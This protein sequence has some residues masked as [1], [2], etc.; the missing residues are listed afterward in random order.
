MAQPDYGVAAPLLGWTGM[1][2]T[3]SPDAAIGAV[4]GGCL[5]W[6]M[7]PEIKATT[8]VPLLVGSLGAGYAFGLPMG[9]GGWAMAFSLVGAT[10][11]YAALESIRYTMKP[12]VEVPPWLN[13][14]RDVLSSL[15]PW[16]GGSNK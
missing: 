9:D 11:G 16:R 2:I 12:G 4:F 14:A 6:A 15:T 3:M 13:W 1:G 10:L 5:F 8:K 7:N